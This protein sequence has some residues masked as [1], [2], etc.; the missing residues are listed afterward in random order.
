MS[1]GLVGG[2]LP[3]TVPG[4][5]PNGITPGLAGQFGN[6]NTLGGIPLG[7][8][9]S[10]GINQNGSFDN[11][12]FSLTNSGTFGPSL[13]NSTSPFGGNAQASGLLT[14]GANSLTNSFLNRL[15]PLDTPP[16]QQYSSSAFGQLTSGTSMFDTLSTVFYGIAGSINPASTVGKAISFAG[17]LI[18]SAGALVGLAQGLRAIGGMKAAE[19]Q[20]PSGVA[21]GLQEEFGLESEELDL[22]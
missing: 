20:I 9:G 19:A 22:S 17:P 11:L 8:F 4:L 12:L 6:F 21:S 16:E 7:G 13:I 1:S 10:V 15:S 5:D 3:G 14:E 18:G 2:V